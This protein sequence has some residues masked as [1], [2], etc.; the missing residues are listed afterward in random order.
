ML[1]EFSGNGSNKYENKQMCK[2][3]KGVTDTKMSK[4]FKEC[5]NIKEKNSWKKLM[6]KCLRLNK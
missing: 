2:I 3:L 1:R 5:K 4:E 6:I